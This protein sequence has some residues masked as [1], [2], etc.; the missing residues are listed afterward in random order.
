MYMS[1]LIKLTHYLSIGGADTHVGSQIRVIVIFIDYHRKNT[2]TV[3]ISDR[4]A[5]GKPDFLAHRL[6]FCV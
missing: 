1:I 3:Q 5:N 2:E 6:L 4:P